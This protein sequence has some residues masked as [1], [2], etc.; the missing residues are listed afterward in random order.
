MPQTFFLRHCRTSIVGHLNSW[1]FDLLKNEPTIINKSLNALNRQQNKQNTTKQT[2]QK[3]ETQ[4]TT[5]TRVKCKKKMKHH[6]LRL[7]N[8][9][10]QASCRDHCSSEVLLIDVHAV[11]SVLLW[12]DPTCKGMF[13]LLVAAWVD[14]GRNALQSAEQ[15]C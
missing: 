14:P 12:Y 4:K 6:A 15:R 8:Q 13:F 11:R 10:S 5:K 3:Q 9:C 1:P 7:L 2:E